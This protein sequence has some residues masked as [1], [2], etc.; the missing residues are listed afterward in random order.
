MF[1]WPVTVFLIDWLKNDWLEKR[2]QKQ[3]AD[4]FAKYTAVCVHRYMNEC[5]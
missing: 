3:H 1:V 4:N 5:V 2:L